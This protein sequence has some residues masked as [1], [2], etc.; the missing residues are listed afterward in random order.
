M[1][2]RPKT[3]CRGDRGSASG[4][5]IVMVPMVMLL[6]GFAVM[7]GR[8][9]TTQQDVTSASRDAARAAALRQYPAAAT[10]DATTAATETLSRRDVACELLTVDV[11]TSQLDPG[12]TVTATVTCRVG[13]GD[14]VGLGIGGSRTVTATST[15][16]VDTYRGG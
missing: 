16:P 4:E 12:G 8:L 10:A 1:T 7:V 11:D 3:R 2:T 6:L 5:L 13:L 15:S 14:V 9:G